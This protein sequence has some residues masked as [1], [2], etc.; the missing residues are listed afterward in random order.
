LSSEEIINQ[1]LFN[2]KII[3]YA[4]EHN[5]DL[6]LSGFLENREHMFRTLGCEQM[7]EQ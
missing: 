6:V 3:D 1:E 4:H 2:Q 5:A 7:V